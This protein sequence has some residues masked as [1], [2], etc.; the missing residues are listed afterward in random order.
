M[1]IRQQHPRADGIQ[2]PTGGLLARL[3]SDDRRRQL[4]A[5]GLDAFGHQPFDAVSIDELA[6]TAGI[7]KG[8]L[9][10][11]F[12]TKRDYYVA[13]LEEAGQELLARFHAAISVDD[14]PQ[15]RLRLGLDAFL[16]HARSHGVAFTTLLRGGIGHDPD[17]MRIID[18]VRK[19]FAN[20]LLTDAVLEDTPP[21]RIAVAGW[22]GFVEGA[23]M[24][25]LETGAAD[26][27]SVRNLCSKVLIAT[28]MTAGRPA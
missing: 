8:L 6:K 4:L 25:W 26:R 24:T 21:M 11:Y 27:D 20:R 14:T 17:V 22:V 9:Y 2:R 10:H 5:L 12:P 1:N 13:V 18:D 3:S 19:A 28:L 23:T 16:D 15:E 7:S